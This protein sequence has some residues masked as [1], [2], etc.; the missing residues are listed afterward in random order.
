M[1]RFNTGHFSLIA[2]NDTS[3]APD[4]QESV[5]K[6]APPRAVEF[7]F[8]LPPWLLKP[9]EVF[10]V[11]ADGVHAIEWSMHGATITIKDT[12]TLDAVYIVAQDESVRAGILQRREMAM[13][14]ETANAV[15]LADIRKLQP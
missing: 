13:D 4:P 5:F 1:E 6:F 15:D 3:Y 7:S 2:A 11:D 9:A 10:R 12:R 14:H 8:K